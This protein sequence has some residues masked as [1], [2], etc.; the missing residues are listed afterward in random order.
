MKPSELKKLII[1]SLDAGADAGEIAGKLEDGGVS[2]D[3]SEG[4]GDKVTDR[5]F[6][7]ALTI[8]RDME[9]TRNLSLVFYRIA[10]TGIAA[11]V[12]LMLSIFIMQDSF[13]FNSFLGLGDTYDETFVYFLTGN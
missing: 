13:S 1:G 11:I 8:N 7:S 2:L 12:I 5:I 4:F 9:F 10:V 6:S 3:F